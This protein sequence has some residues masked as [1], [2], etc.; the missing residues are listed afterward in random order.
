[1]QSLPAKPP[2]LDRSCTVSS[3][4]TICIQN[5]CCCGKGILQVRS[6]DWWRTFELW[7]IFS[8]AFSVY[9]FRFL[10]EKQSPSYPH[11]TV[12][13]LFLLRRSDSVLE[14]SI[15]KQTESGVPRA[16]AFRWVSG[17]SHTAV[18]EA[19]E[20][21]F[22]FSSS[23]FPQ[24]SLMSKLACLLPQR[25][26]VWRKLV[27]YFRKLYCYFGKRINTFSVVWVFL[28]VFCCCSFFC[29]FT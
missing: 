5:K 4:E 1:M 7:F 26:F 20:L 13:F 22:L 16:R 14:S 23:S 29:R 21:V 25:I 18:E 24:M 3:P 10:Q 8:Y 6:L 12:S 9:L 19:E 11:F 17:M 15:R 2:R 28:F 27:F